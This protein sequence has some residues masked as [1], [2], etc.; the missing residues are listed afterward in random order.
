MTVG[1][2][3]TRN[4]H[5][6]ISDIVTRKPQELAKLRKSGSCAT[7]GLLGH[8]PVCDAHCA[9]TQANDRQIGAVHQFD[10]SVG[11][12]TNQQSHSPA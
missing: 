5:Q 11:V 10:L 8:D 2:F 7:F 9:P 6:T 4:P 12:S 3:Q 1:T